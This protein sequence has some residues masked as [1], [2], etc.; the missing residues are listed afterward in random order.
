MGKSSD[1]NAVP[2]GT[3]LIFG[4]WACTTDGSSGFTGH[5]ITPKD[6]EAKLDDRPAETDDAPK[7]GRNQVPLELILENPR[8]MSTPTHTNESAESDTNPNSQKFQFSQT[9]AKY[10]DYLKSIKHPKISTL[11]Y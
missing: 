8:N 2:E 11:N 4:S 5:L 9:L 7:L 10:V 3:T 6:P 1:A